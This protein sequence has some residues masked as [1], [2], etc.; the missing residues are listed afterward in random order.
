MELIGKVFYSYQRHRVKLDY[1]CNTELMP[2]E[3][4]P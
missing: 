2:I 4:H 3:F 1:H